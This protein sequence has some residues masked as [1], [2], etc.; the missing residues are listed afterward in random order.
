MDLSD[1]SQGSEEENYGDEKE[2]I[3]SLLATVP[4][5]KDLFH[6]H[7]KVGE[8][9]FS[10]VF[11]ATL[12]LSNGSKKFAIKHLIPTCHPTRIQRELNCLKQIGGKDH[13][14]G[15]ELC[16]RNSGSVVFVM[17]FMRHDKFPEYV[18]N[19]TVSEIKDYMRALLTALR[20]VHQFSI[21]H[22]D[23]KPSNFLYDR[24]NKRYLLVDFGL[25]ERY[26][27]DA[28]KTG[29]VK[30]PIPI[31]DPVKR[32][33]EMEN[34]RVSLNTLK[35]SEE[36]CYCFGKSR[37]CSLCLVRPV[38]TAPRAGTPGFRAPE[39]LL[40]YPA[41]TPAIDI[42]ASGVIMLSILSGS[43]PFFRSPDDCTALAE[44]VT[45]FGSDKMH[46]CARKLGKKITIAE[47]IPPVDI[48]NLCKKLRRRGKNLQ[49][50]NL[51]SE[52]ESLDRKFPA[53]AFDLLS[54]L[55]EVDHRLRITAA[56]AL[57]H[58]F[59]KL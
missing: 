4:A 16:L 12:K 58:P 51:T 56:Q 8:G 52:E 44:I 47:D 22:R 2:E 9:S 27:K 53:E 33:R 32:K 31:P 43:Q 55:M 21:I 41:Q 48:I 23:I 7:Y 29:I 10:S 39:V 11:L 19:M 49:D 15:L 57:N 50:L 45:L 36:K 38:Q 30:P 26:K 5:L 17:P 25:A 46:Q 3:A 54:K 6:L 24:S 20:R 28:N 14:A 35:K 18:Q 13:V 42:W 59:L 37:V 1:N 34:S 40:K